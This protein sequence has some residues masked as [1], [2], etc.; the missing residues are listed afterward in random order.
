MFDKYFAKRKWSFLCKHLSSLL[1]PVLRY[2]RMCLVKP[3]SCNPVLYLLLTSAHAADIA[4]S[5]RHS[6]WWLCLISWPQSWNRL[7]TATPPSHASLV[8][9]L[10]NFL[11]NYF[12]FLS[13]HTTAPSPGLLAKDL[14]S[15]IVEKTVISRNSLISSPTSLQTQL[16]THTTHTAVFCLPSCSDE[17]SVCAYEVKS[18]TWVLTLSSPLSVIQLSLASSLGYLRQF[19]NML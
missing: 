2:C 5:I 10:G 13:Y 15:Y 16:R 18:P 3:D 14:V 12:I 6:S 1:M 17:R 8:N 9:L 4:E 7:S 19:A 11:S